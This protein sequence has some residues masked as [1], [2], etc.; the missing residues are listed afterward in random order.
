MKYFKPDAIAF[1]VEKIL[2]SEKVKPECVADLSQ[3]LNYYAYNAGRQI[4][5]QNLDILRE[6]VIKKI[7]SVCGHETGGELYKSARH[8]E[9]VI[10][11][12]DIDEFI[13]AAKNI[14]NVFDKFFY[15]RGID[16]KQL[17]R[18]NR[19]RTDK[20]TIEYIQKPNDLS[21]GRVIRE[22]QTFLS[23]DDV[24]YVLDCLKRGEPR[25][26]TAFGSRLPDDDK[27]LFFALMSDCFPKDTYYAVYLCK[28]AI[29]ENDSEKLNNALRRINDQNQRAMILPTLAAHARKT[30]NRELMEKLIISLETETQKQPCLN[31]FAMLSVALN[32]RARMTKAVGLLEAA[33]FCVQGLRSYAKLALGL[34]DYDTMEKAVAL[35]EDRIDDPRIFK[36]YTR[37]VLAMDNRNKMLKVY[38][39]V[40][41]VHDDPWF[42]KMY[43]KLAMIFSDYEGMVYAEILMRR[44]PNHPEIRRTCATLEYRIKDEIKQ[45]SHERISE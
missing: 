41:K 10:E 40:K 15:L 24:Y 35:L 20:K 45:R 39:E 13:E 28:Q 7:I 43:A 42:V 1:H 38:E 6:E 16:K 3:Q 2:Q 18:D 9:E 44:F 14:G 19:E 23:G 4:Q 22:L 32:D 37:L 12:M 17:H 27:L 26:I 29:L 11:T 31:E 21:V 5:R 25:L 30:S 8:L 33:P 36:I 34:Y